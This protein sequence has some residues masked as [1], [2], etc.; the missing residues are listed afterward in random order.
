MLQN[1]GLGLSLYAGGFIHADD[2]RT[3]SSSTESLVISIVESFSKENVLKLNVQKCEIVHFGQAIP[4][5]YHQAVNSHLPTKAAAKCLG[6]WWL[7]PNRSVEENTK[8]ARGCFF[9]YGTL[10]S[11]QGDINPL[12]TK[13][14]IHTC[15]MSVLL[16][17][18][19]LTEKS[20]Q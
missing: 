14:A 7:L 5:P 8:K 15:V 12:S 20:V 10:G 6:Y 18:W 9:K 4:S 19:I 13:S 11:F 3:L 17:N 1:S 16:Y 2:I